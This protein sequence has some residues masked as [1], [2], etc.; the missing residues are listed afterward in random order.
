MTDSP[1][2][3]QTLLEEEATVPNAPIPGKPVTGKVISIQNGKI[4]VEIDDTHIGIIAGREATDG[5]N[6]AKNLVVEDEVSAYV[7]EDENDEGYYVLSLRKAGR[8]KA[9]VKLAEMKD[10]NETLGVVVKNANKGG[11]MTEFSGIRAFIPVSQLAPE[12]YPRVSSANTNEIL[13]RLQRLVGEKLTVQP[14]TVDINENKLIFSEKAAM[15]KRRLE[16]LKNLKIGSKIK[17]KVSG[18]VNFGIFIIFNEC[19]EGLVHLSE[20]AWGRVTDAANHARLGEEKEA[21]VIG[22]DENKISLSMRRLTPD[23]WAK[24]VEKFSIGDIVDGEIS[25][26]VSYGAIVNIGNDL[27]GLLHTSE[28]TKDDNAESPEINFEV[29]D[30]IRVKIVE[31]NP[32][33]HR[34]SLSIKTSAEPEEKKTKKKDVVTKKSSKKDEKTEKEPTKKKKESK[35]KKEEVKKKTAPTKKKTIKKDTEKKSE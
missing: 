30:K 2:L 18:I 7:V 34:I 22:I 20:I 35:E 33:E 31:I 1:S 3:M 15:N 27:S 25:K 9:W 12:H 16:S 24:L 11:L 13:S 5:F 19:L 23:P 8:E 29:N 4:L 26:I 17:G 21:V 6:T 28:I 14:I 10:T 32:K